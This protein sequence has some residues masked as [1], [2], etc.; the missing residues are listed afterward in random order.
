MSRSP[1]GKPV[2]SNGFV[3]QSLEGGTGMNKK[4]VEVLL[5]VNDPKE[6]ELALRALKKTNGAKR[7]HI[8]HDRA[9]ALEFIFGREVPAKHGISN[10]PK[11]ILLDLKLPEADR[12]EILQ[13]LKTDDRTRSIPVVAIAS[14]RA[15]REIVEHDQSGR[16]LRKQFVNPIHLV[17]QSCEELRA[18]H[19]GRQVELIVG[20]LPFCQ[21]DPWLLKQVWMHLLGNALKFTR[22]RKFARIEVGCRKEGDETVFFVKDNG[23]GFDMRYAGKL[24]GVFQRLHSA[25]PYEG[26]GV[27]LATVKRIVERHGG[28]VWAEAQLNRGA[29]FYFTLGEETSEALQISSNPN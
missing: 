7:V 22:K 2:L 5:I 3:T 4:P 20:D 1:S 11:L 24:F 18:E 9:Q 28:R 23:I 15:E 21:A 25:E 6:E 10:R 19:E 14:S 16:P 12:L 27:G 8:A 13:R 17:S 26:V 29:T